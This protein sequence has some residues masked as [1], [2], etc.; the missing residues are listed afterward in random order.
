VETWEAEY[1]KFGS[2]CA[3]TLAFVHDL[4]CLMVLQIYPCK[5]YNFRDEKNIYHAEIPKYSSE[6]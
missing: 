2:D 6:S 3:D 5:N 4:C 1:Y